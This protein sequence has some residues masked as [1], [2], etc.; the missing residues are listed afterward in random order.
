MINDIKLKKHSL[1]H[2]H[3]QYQEDQ[4]GELMGYERTLTQA[5]HVTSSIIPNHNPLYRDQKMGEVIKIITHGA[6]ASNTIN[7]IP[8]YHCPDFFSNSMPY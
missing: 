4:E 2:N 8:A 1:Y 7:A 5:L 3:D 6:R